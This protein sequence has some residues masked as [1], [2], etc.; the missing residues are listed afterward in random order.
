[1]KILFLLKS[2]DYSGAENVILTL[3]QLLPSDYE[4]Y[5]ASPDGP[6]REVVKSKNQNFI[7]M[8][9]PNLKS[10]KKIIHEVQPDIIHASDFSMSLLAT[11]ALPKAPIISH[12]HNDPTWITKSF[13]FRKIAYNLALNRISKVIC[14]SQAVV[15]EFDNR[16]LRKKSVV[17]PNIVNGNMIEEKAQEIEGV[18]S[19]I[20]MVGR[21]TEQK[22]PLLFCRIIKEIK[23]N[24]PSVRA[25]IIGQ[26]ELKGKIENYIQSNDLEANVKL[27]GFKRNPYPYM[28]HTKVCIMPSRF[29]GFGLAAVEMLTLGKPVIASNVGGLRKI[30]NSSC[31]CLIKSRNA[32]E[33]ARQ[34]L[35]IIN[36]N[37]YSKMSYNAKIRSRQFTNSS[38][39]LAKIISVYSEV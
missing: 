13:D 1:M 32:K 30:L 7:A 5:Y 2:H 16:N 20:C 17:I 12:L 24:I 35:K 10:V 14:V 34:Y 33:Y 9:R 23:K 25:L 29:E 15:N 31:G 4:T 3:M 11:L 37:T 39:F 6:I 19:D 36:P 21:L 28:E 38:K 18:K 22:D 8:D 26:G 27:L